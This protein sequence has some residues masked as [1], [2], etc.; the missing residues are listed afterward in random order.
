MLKT[1]AS[2]LQ[3]MQVSIVYILFDKANIV[4]AGFYG[5]FMNGL[6]SI[7]GTLGAIPCVRPQP[8]W[9]CTSLIVIL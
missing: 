3:P 5:T 4:L 6:G 8:A 9:L 2:T 7:A 1:L